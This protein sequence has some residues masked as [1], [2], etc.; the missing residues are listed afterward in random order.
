[1][2]RQ[3]LAACLAALILALSLPAMADRGHH[4]SGRFGSDFHAPA[5][6]SQGFHHQHHHRAP[7]RHGHRTHRVERHIYYV[8]PRHHRHRHD[9]HRHGDHRHHSVIPLVTVDGY[10]LLRI[11]VNH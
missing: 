1:M 3:L 7:L 2:N 10:P 9:R 5:H 6:F 8:T 11:R 4:P